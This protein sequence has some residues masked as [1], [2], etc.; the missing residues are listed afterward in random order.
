MRRERFSFPDYY[1]YGIE[2]EMCNKKIFDIFDICK[3]DERLVRVNRSYDEILNR[4]GKKY[5]DAMACRSKIA[6]RE[7]LDK[8]W[9]VVPEETSEN[10]ELGSEVSSPVFYN[11]TDDLQNIREILDILKDNGAEV[12]EI[13]G[14]HVHIGALPFQKSYSKL[15]NFFLFHLLFE[16]VY[17]KFSA[18]GNFGHVREYAVAYANPVSSKVRN[19]ELNE[20]TLKKYIREN[21]SSDYKD[22]ALHFKDFLIDDFTCGTSFESRVFNGTLESAVIENYIDAVLAG[23]YYSVSENF[24]QAKM[25][26][27]CQEVVEMR[28]DWLGFQPFVD[29]ADK[30]VDE[31]VENVFTDSLAKDL[32]Y[33]QYSGKYLKK[34]K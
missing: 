8:Y 23:V 1:P 33:E 13:C 9:G 2:V 31:F 20:G 7:N 27:R 5:A 28:K 30:M 34:V 22:G 24:D 21:S 4:Y 15:L 3:S 6:L 29:Y 10:G 26:R 14:L 25:I 12:N 32:F 16:P 19:S 17:Y 11:R 18:M